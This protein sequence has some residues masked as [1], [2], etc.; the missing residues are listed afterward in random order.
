MSTIIRTRSP[1]F[2]R[3]TNYPSPTYNIDYF[4]LILTVR[5]GESGVLLPCDN[6][7]SSYTLQKKVLPNETSVTFEISELVKDHIVQTFNGS[8]TLSALY[9]SIWVD[10]LIT[11]YETSGAAISPT[12]STQYLA[13]E[14]Y[15]TFK[16]GANYVVEPEAMIT[17]DYMQ[18]SKTSNI[19]IPLN[20]ERVN[21]IAWKNNGVIINTANVIDN[22][23]STQKIVYLTIN[24]IAQEFDE[25]EVT[26]DTSLTRSITLEEIDECK[27][28]VFK[29]TFLNRWGALQDLF[30]F[31]KSTESLNVNRE[32]YNRSIFNARHSSLTPNETPPPDCDVVVSYNSYNVNEHSDKTFNVNGRE[33]IQL[34]TG[35][36]KELMNS[37]FEELMVS[38][39]IWLTDSNNV[40]N[41]V[42]LTDSSFT[43]KTSLN[44]RMINYTMNFEM[45]FDLVNNIR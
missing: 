30:F 42:K 16:E 18:Y 37:S 3:T 32:N 9:Q 13:Q 23:F 11:G 8:Y 36:V 24:P 19:T 20:K 21:S 5:S 4:K 43:T 14:G 27:Y 15:N 6:I 22:G 7:Y 12:V 10:A 25:I 34:N 40:I 2:I 26:Y 1:F 28:E 44:D 17:A 38:E 41:P 45:A 33:S 31:K 39:Y 29:I 35:F